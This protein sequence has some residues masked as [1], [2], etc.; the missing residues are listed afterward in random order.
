MLCN[1]AE[2]QSLADIKTDAIMIAV[3]TNVSVII[4]AAIAIALHPVG[5]SK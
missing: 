1:N 2:R 4:V 5:F 3:H